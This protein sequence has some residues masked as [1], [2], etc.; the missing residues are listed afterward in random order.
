[1]STGRK[2]AASSSKEDRPGIKRAVKWTRQFSHAGPRFQPDYKPI[3]GTKP[4]FRYAGK[5]LLLERNTEEVAVMYARYLCGKRRT[6]DIE[7]TLQQNFFEDWQKY[8]SSKEKQ[9]I[10]KFELCDFSGLVKKLQEDKAKPLTKQER[11]AQKKKREDMMNQYK[12]VIVD[13]RRELISNFTV[14]PPGLYMGR[15]KNDNIGRVKPRIKPKD[16]TINC[17]DRHIPKA[18]GNSKWGAIVHDKSVMWLA[19]WYDPITKGPKYI[20]LHPSSKIKNDIEEEKFQTVR[21]LHRKI[22]EVRKHY[23]KDLKSKKNETEGEYATRQIA[24]AVYLIDNFA[25]RV[26]NEKPEGATDTVGCCSLRVEHLS[27]LASKNIRLNFL[28]KDSIRYEKGHQVSN[29]VYDNL[30]DFTR[31]FDGKK[32]T[33]KQLLFDSIKTKHVNDYLYNLMKGQGLTA[34]VFRTFRATQHFEEKLEEYSKFHELKATKSTPEDDKMKM[35]VFKKANLAV[36]QLLNHQTLSKPTTKGK[37]IKVNEKRI[38]DAQ[39]KL[40]NLSKGTDEHRKTTA[41]LVVLKHELD[42]KVEQRTY[43]LGTSKTNYI[44][45]QV[46]AKWCKKYKVDITKVYSKVQLGKFRWALRS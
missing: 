15:G 3:S 10:K 29:A 9:Q 2:R 5:P 13:G 19:S 30:Q 14:E 23:E 1:M 12:T 40:N 27:L 35:I 20:Q 6:R 18:P 45:P 46:S 22:L 28:G 42:L 39:Y 11:A 41:Q 43:A 21:K 31:D 16:I 33:K 25:L 44:D 24:T 34:K 4:L 38:K 32:K 26:G 36:A 17:D 37:A 8:M 7:K